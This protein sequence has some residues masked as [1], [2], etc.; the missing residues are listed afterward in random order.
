MPTASARDIPIIGHPPGVITS[1][2]S[3]DPQAP[4]YG[5]P[6]VPGIDFAVK[7]PAL[8]VNEVI[9]DY[10]AAFLALTGIAKTLAPGDP[11]RLHLLVVCYWL[12]Q[13]RNIIDYTG[14]QN[15][16]KYAVGDNLDNLAALYGQRTI[17]LPAAKALTTLR[18]TLE[19]ALAFSATIPKG[20][21]CQAPNSIVFETLTDGTIAAGDLTVDVPGR[22]MTEGAVG[23][24]FL[25]GQLVGIINWNQPYALTVSNTIVTAGG[26]DAENDEQYRYRVWLAI[27]S[28]S[29]C[30][31]HDAY[32]FWALAASP[33][34][35]Q[36]VVYS[37]EDI[38]GEVWIYPLLQGGQ[39]PTQPILDLVLATCSRNTRRPLTDWVKVFAPTVF[40]YALN[41]DYYVDKVNE[42]LLET[43]QNNVE[44]AAL[45]W[46]LWQRSAISRDLN[47]GELTK[48]CLEAGAKRIVV[49][50]PTPPFQVLA[51]NQLAV[52]TSAD[53]IINFAGLE[54]A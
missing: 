53:P 47:C 54:D 51:Y 15:L 39:L 19:A 52:H 11:V 1:A 18:F 3:G 8:I 33:D 21:L 23:N 44:Q 22:S 17:R 41:F 20:T 43:I 14:K 42:V 28:F 9:L 16:L 12:S 50:T 45:D 48:R 49:H 34:I 27:E 10:Q 46:I 30:G 36:A 25:P 29:T 32:E 24:G 6:Y 13:Q 5:L 4:N 35:M 38:A 31:P 37:H 2:K 26:S 7:D 40:P